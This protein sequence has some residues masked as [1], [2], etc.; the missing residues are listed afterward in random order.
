MDFTTATTGAP[1]RSQ[2]APRQKPIS[3]SPFHHGPSEGTRCRCSACPDHW[4]HSLPSPRIHGRRVLESH[5]RASADVETTFGRG[6]SHYSVR[7]LQ[8]PP[9]MH[10]HRRRTFTPLDR[11]SAEVETR[12]I[13][14][15][16][17]TSVAH[18]SPLQPQKEQLD[19]LG[20]AQ[21]DRGSAGARVRHSSY[22][23]GFWSCLRI[24]RP[25]TPLSARIDAERVEPAS[26]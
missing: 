26:R 17:N 8:R 12:S 16:S 19:L 22:S 15:G 24:S 7:Q 1:R 13:C 20:F 6:G 9:S 10:G 14:G 5:D 2:T 11:A 3:L 23:S 21:L 25:N 18:P 4:L